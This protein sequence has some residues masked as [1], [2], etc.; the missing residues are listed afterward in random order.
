MKSNDGKKEL[1]EFEHRKKSTKILTTP[2]ILLLT[3]GAVLAAALIFIYYHMTDI[4]IYLIGIPG[5]LTGI[6]I[7]IIYV[8]IREK[9]KDS[10]IA[11]SII[12]KAMKND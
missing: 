9:M 4:Q 6:I 3:G 2:N 7:I 8:K 1:I 11:A 12:E 5:I 10:D